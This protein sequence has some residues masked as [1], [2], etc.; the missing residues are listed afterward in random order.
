MKK[1]IFSNP[2]KLIIEIVCSLSA[3][4]LLLVIIV[5][6]SSINH[7]NMGNYKKTLGDIEVDEINIRIDNK[8][9][10]LFEQSSRVVDYYCK[11]DFDGKTE[12]I[13]LYLTANQEAMKFRIDERNALVKADDSSI[14][15]EKQN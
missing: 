7:G 9:I 8:A 6:P 2:N 15:F 3:I 10:L 1:I 11:I 5:L 14:V 13:Y 4:L 12:L